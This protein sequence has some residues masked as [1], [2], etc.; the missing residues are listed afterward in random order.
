MRTVGVKRRSRG[1]D[2]RR[3]RPRPTLKIVRKRIQLEAKPT[4]HAALIRLDI[5]TSTIGRRLSEAVQLTSIAAIMLAS[6]YACEFLLLV[7]FWVGALVGMVIYG[8]VYASTWLPD[9]LD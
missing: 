5:V 6:G 9:A 4:D 8:F 1:L 7:K 2:S 3:T